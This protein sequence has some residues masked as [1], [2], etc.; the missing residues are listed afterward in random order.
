MTSAMHVP[1]L[2]T[3]VAITLYGMERSGLNRAFPLG[4]RQMLRQLLHGHFEKAVRGGKINE[5]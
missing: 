4:E 2:T 1:T 3:A 5:G